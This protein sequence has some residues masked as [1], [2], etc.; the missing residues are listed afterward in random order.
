MFGES[1]MYVHM[2]NEQKTNGGKKKMEDSTKNQQSGVFI[3]GPVI[4]IF[5]RLPVKKKGA[6]LQRVL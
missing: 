2:G 1:L 5:L 6:I 3:F 4:T